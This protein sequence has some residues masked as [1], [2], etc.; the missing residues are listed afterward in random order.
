MS[1]S[2]CACLWQASPARPKV[3]HQAGS[4]TEV[5]SL[6]GD[7]RS[8][9]NASAQ[10]ALLNP[11]ICIVAGSGIGV[12]RGAESRRI[13]STGRQQTVQRYGELGGPRRGLRTGHAHTGVTRE[14][15][16]ASCLLHSIAGRPGVPADQE[17]WR[18][19]GARDSLRRRARRFGGGNTNRTDT[20]VGTG[21]ERGANRPGW[22]E[23]VL[24]NHSTDEGGEVRPKRPAGGKVKPGMTFATAKHRSRH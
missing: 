9:G 20:G 24:A 21:R 22:A 16:R 13:A 23:A 10:A 18:R 4:R 8:R 5:L 14:L 6:R 15:G 2:G 11:E 1:P 7:V 3:S 19:R 12:V 17:P